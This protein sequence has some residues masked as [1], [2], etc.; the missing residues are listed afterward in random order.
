MRADELRVERFI[1]KP[2]AHPAG[3]DLVGCARTTTDETMVAVA[4]FREDALGE[5]S[6]E[7]QPVRVR[8]RGAGKFGMTIR[9]GTQRGKVIYRETIPLTR[10]VGSQ[11]SHQRR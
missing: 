2:H 8:Q 11:P 6:A 1:A 7:L 4:V 10:N 5:G 9:I 3:T